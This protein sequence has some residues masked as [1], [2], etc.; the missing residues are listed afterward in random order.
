[1]ESDCVRQCFNIKTEI[2]NILHVR[3]RLNVGYNT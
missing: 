3:G 1:M 2:I